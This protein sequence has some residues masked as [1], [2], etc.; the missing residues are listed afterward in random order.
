M[1]ENDG[2]G[3]PYARRFPNADKFTFDVR[4]KEAAEAVLD[5]E[6]RFTLRKSFQSAPNSPYAKR[7][8]PQVDVGIEMKEVHRED[9]IEVAPEDESSEEDGVIQLEGEAH[10]LPVELVRKPSMQSLR[11]RRDPLFQ[12]TRTKRTRRVIHRNGKRNVT[13]MHIP[14]RSARFF[15]DFVTTLIEEQ[16]RYTLALFAFTFFSCWILFALLWYLIAYAHGDLKRDPET[17]ERL[18]D[19]GRPCIEEATGMASFLLFSIETQVGIGFGVRFPTEECPEALFLMVVQLILSVAIE[20]AMVGIV[21][22]KMVRPTKSSS[23][24][25]KFSRKAVVCCQDGRLCLMFR[26]CDTQENHVIGTTVKAFWMEARKTREGERINQFQHTLT[27]E[28]SG[29]IFLLWPS[30]VV[31]V[32]DERSP[33]YDVS[34][35]DLLSKNFEIVVTMTGG[36]RSTGQ[37]TQTRTSYLPRDI[38]WGHKFLNL[39]TYSHERQA[40]VADYEKFDAL[41]QID[42]PLCSA[43]RLEEIFTEVTTIMQHDMYSSHSHFRRISEG[44]WEG[45]ADEPIVFT[46]ERHNSHPELKSI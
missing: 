21:Y 4:Q 9:A 26:I 12:G 42:T 7:R 35:R 39:L 5:E 13:L 20:G 18:S 11:Q 38:L 19:G 31:H 43:R 40:Y 17:G 34:A 32:I 8:E 44:S 2:S 29:H 46:A 27:I 14:Q 24:Q 33:L 15:K 1:M 22:A 6:Q 25:L 36:C 30:T 45:S 3:S 28:D 10:N 16:W 23:G 37:L 41:T